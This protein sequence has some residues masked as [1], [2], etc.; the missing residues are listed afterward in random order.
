MAGGIL[1]N[2]LTSI[3]FLVLI[4]QDLIVAALVPWREEGRVALLPLPL[5][6][7][8]SIILRQYV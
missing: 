6:K 7:S 4:M 3:S 8:N 2:L 1:V 5:M